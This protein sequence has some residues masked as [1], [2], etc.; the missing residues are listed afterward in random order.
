MAR[1]RHSWLPMEQSWGRLFHVVAYFILGQHC[2]TAGH[3]GYSI[4]DC[5]MM[6]TGIWHLHGGT[7]ILPRVTMQVENP[8]SITTLAQTCNMLQH[9]S[10]QETHYLWQR[11]LHGGH[12]ADPHTVTATNIKTNMCHIHTSIVSGRL[13]TGEGN[14]RV[15]H[16]PP[17]HI[18]KVVYR[19]MGANATRQ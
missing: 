6:H 10:A 4:G 7:L 19:P 8:A 11:P 16:T 12:S 15:L 2:Q 1:G 14:G 9:S 18:T 5:H 3:A 13:A 17:P